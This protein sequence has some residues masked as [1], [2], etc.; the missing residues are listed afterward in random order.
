[1]RKARGSAR[2]WNACERHER[3]GGF[4]EIPLQM[5]AEAQAIVEDA[6]HARLLPLSGGRE[7]RARA[8]VEVEVPEAVD[9]GDLVGTRLS[10]SERLSAGLLAMAAFARAQEPCS[11]MNLASVG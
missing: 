10:R 5:A 1:M 3:L 7:D 11:F 9:V 8:L 6:E 4:V 2:F